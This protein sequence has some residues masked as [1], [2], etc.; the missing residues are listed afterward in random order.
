MNKIKQSLLSIVIGL[1]LAG[2]VSFAETVWK[3]PTADPTGNNVS[4]PI[5]VSTNPQ[6]FGDSSSAGSK[7]LNMG[8][9]T[10][11]LRIEGGL[12]VRGAGIFEGNVGIG[13]VTP[14]SPAPNSQSGNVDV[15]DV[16][17]RSANSGAGQWV[18]QMASSNGGV[19]AGFYDLG[20]AAPGEYGDVIVNLGFKPKAVTANA[21]WTR[22]TSD[23]HV[24]ASITLVDNGFVFHWRGPHGSAPNHFND[25]T[26]GFYYMASTEKYPPPPLPPPPQCS[27]TKD[28][29]GDGL[30][31][32][33]ND[34]GCSSATD[35]D[36][37]DVIIPPPGL[38]ASLI[39]FT[40]SCN[41]FVF[42]IKGESGPQTEKLVTT[43]DGKGRIIKLAGDV[44][45]DNSGK[46]YYVTMDITWGYFCI[47]DINGKAAA[48]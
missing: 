27:N 1:A 39:T 8:N 41:S 7:T 19:I 35:N 15:N 32:Y 20:S 28:D 11:S 33:P 2:G 25:P 37:R 38:N 46:S 22:D 29:D 17:V 18:S 31:D 23:E 26:F 13:T 10:G 9:G 24:T 42:D 48:Y 6:T 44:T 5:N 21:N 30:I 34:P 36:E 47:A 14:Q 4:A 43:T 40:W 45:Y 12:G 3:G 16:W